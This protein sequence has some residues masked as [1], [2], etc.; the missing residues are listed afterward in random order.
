MAHSSYAVKREQTHHAFEAAAVRVLIIE[1]EELMAS[2]LQRGLQRDGY[3]A[4]VTLDGR[5]GLW[6][7]TEN[8]YDAILLD[9]M[10]PGMNG[11]TLV[12]ELRRRDNW[13]PVL[14]LTAKHGEYD[15]AEALDGGADDFLSKPFSYVV[16]KAR[17]RAL[18]RRGRRP[19]PAILE[20][21]ELALDPAVRECTVA[22][23]PVVLTNTEFRL[24]EYL[25]RRDGEVATK[26]ELLEHVWDGGYDRDS[27][28]VDVYIGYLRRKVDAPF[29]RECIRTVRG[30]G[31]R[32]VA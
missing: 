24:L 22:G 20:A 28:V 16:L 29:D 19:R 32:Y 5:E 6:M 25:L 31:Y 9:I 10:L 18:I 27:K 2:S 11:Y 30:V 12:D 17:L 21:G 4:D 7:A 14:M 23:T 1:D 13:T 26:H 15:Q 8:E 3:A